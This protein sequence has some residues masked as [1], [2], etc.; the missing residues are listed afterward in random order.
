M[1]GLITAMALQFVLV[2]PTS[3]CNVIHMGFKTNKFYGECWERGT[4]NYLGTV[5]WTED[6]RGV[7]T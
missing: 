3:L 5:L 4:G 2:T 1:T 7:T 6:P